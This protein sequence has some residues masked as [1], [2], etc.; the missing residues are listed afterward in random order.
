[1]FTLGR[2]LK[3]TK[4]RTNCWGFSFARLKLCL[5]FCK[6]WVGRH[7]GRFFHKLIWSAWNRSGFFC[8]DKR[9][10]FLK[11]VWRRIPTV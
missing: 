2:F 10:S 6:K 7:F 3:I 9:N 8:K 11:Y 4:S 5:H 1:L